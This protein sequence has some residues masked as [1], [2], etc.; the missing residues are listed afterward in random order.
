MWEMCILVHTLSGSLCDMSIE[1]VLNITYIAY[2]VTHHRILQ[3]MKNY[4]D[5]N[6]SNISIIQIFQAILMRE[7]R[8]HLVMTLLGWRHW[9]FMEQKKNSRM[10]VIR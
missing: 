10:G 5:N 2:N 8:Q 9:L 4:T 6:G 7:R 1:E 3:S